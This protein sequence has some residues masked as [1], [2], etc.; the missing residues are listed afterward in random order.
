M[1]HHVSGIPGT[2]PY[3]FVLSAQVATAVCGLW[4]T[5]RTSRNGKSNL[6][7]SENDNMLPILSEEIRTPD[8]DSLQYSQGILKWASKTMTRQ[9]D[10]H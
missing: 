6:R 7:L 5:A 3:F 8:V 1:C 2:Y 9:A 10:F 4:L